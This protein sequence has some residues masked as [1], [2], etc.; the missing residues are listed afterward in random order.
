LTTTEQWR[1]TLESLRERVETL[2]REQPIASGAAFTSW[3]AQTVSALSRALSP[4]HHITEAFIALQ[5]SSFY[6]ELD[7]A[8]FR[9]AAGQA[10][11]YLEAATV[12]LEH[13]AEE[14]DADSWVDEELWAFVQVD[15]ANEHWGKAVS[16]AALFAEDRIRR[17]T[18]QSARLVGKDLMDAVFGKSGDYRLGL[19][20]GEKEGWK[21]LAM[22]ISM[23]LRNPAAH[24]IDNRDDHRRYAMGV[25]GACS[26]LLTQLRYEHGQRFHDVSPVPDELDD[27][28]TASGQ[29]DR[30]D[31]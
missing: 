1:V 9:D 28:V 11:G 2:A 3:R 21:L 23:A 31:E 17:W 15:V 30:R 10:S 27:A 26:L 16:Q 14:T 18:G 25:I 4:A 13:A 5:W 24:R 7:E 19:V 20:D 8:T 29:T 12:E 22:G 6:D